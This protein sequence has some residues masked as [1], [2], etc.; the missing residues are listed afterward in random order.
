M[1]FDVSILPETTV[2]PFA[3]IVL[4]LFVA[5]LLGLVIGF[6][7]EI[8]NKA[9]GLRTHALVSL[10]AAAFAILT[11]ELTQETAWLGENVRQD[12]LRVVEAII[13][14]IAF[15]G[16]G[17]IIQAGTNI[18][19]ITTGASIWL[20]GSAGLASGIGNFAIAIVLVVISLLLLSL[21][22]L[23]ERRM[24]PFRHDD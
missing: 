21:L 16:A 2:T 15:L 1:S 6:E 12:P 10:A 23:V 14:G 17:A 13:T 5:A 4:R 11:I 20:A 3:E 8:R 9:A 7:R 22:L 24:P 19:G 18:Y